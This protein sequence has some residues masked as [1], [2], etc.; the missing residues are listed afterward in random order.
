[1]T[2]TTETAGVVIVPTT[3]V[4]DTA[5]FMEQ[6]IRRRKCFQPRGMYTDTWP[7]NKDFWEMMFGD[8]LQGRLGLFHLVK[9]LT[10][11]LKL[12]SP[13]FW[14]CKK[15]LEK[16]L[17]VY[18]ADEE[19]KLILALKNGQFKGRKYTSDDIQKMKHSKVFLQRY[20][21]FLPKAPKLY[22][23]LL[24]GID[25]WYT[26]FKEDFDK[27]LATCAKD[28]LKDIRNQKEHLGHIQDIDGIDMYREVP[29]GPRSRSE[30]GHGLS[31]FISK[32]PESH[33]EASH[34]PLANYANTGMN[35][36]LADILTLRGLACRNVKIRHKLTL[37][38]ETTTTTTRKVPYYLREE[39]AHPNHSMLSYL[40]KQ[41]K[42]KGLKLPFK[43]VRPLPED[44]GEL[45]LSEYYQ[46]QLKRNQRRLQLLQ[47]SMFVSDSDPARKRCMCNECY[48]NDYPLPRELHIWVE[49]NPEQEVRETSRTN[50]RTGEVTTMT[51]VATK[52][53]LTVQ[54]DRAVSIRPVLP[55]PTV[56]MALPP[57]TA[58][59][60]DLPPSQELLPMTWAPQPPQQQ[61]PSILHP[62]LGPYPRLMPQM[63]YHQILL[64]A[65]P[66]RTTAAGIQI[67]VCLKRTHYDWVAA[68]SGKKPPGRVPHDDDCH[69]KIRMP[70]KRRK[71]RNAQDT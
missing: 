22:Q 3:S 15:A 41:A 61:W 5:H 65:N 32:R 7:H 8:T 11:N 36:K 17:Y 13:K 42:E 35:A 18:V 21:K 24:Q 51:V 31:T 52:T 49:N 34:G 59:P 50:T 48:N 47:S 58:A 67:C 30:Q 63:P 71:K 45:F 33:L 56:P 23:V 27:G 6:M 53:Y 12:D 19:N 40:N 10:K 9:R 26:Q 54:N 4:Q 43:N 38:S 37:R 29:P 44:N 28:V 16:V 1:M 46:E 69:M 57:P 66:L 25:E 55:L 60:I 2:E 70:M 62:P 68:S 39:P 14:Q 64:P 20:G